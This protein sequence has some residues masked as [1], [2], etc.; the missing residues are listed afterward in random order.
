METKAIEFK[1]RLTYQ[2]ANS[3][4]VDAL[5]YLDKYTENDNKI[6]NELVQKEMKSFE[7][8]DYLK[9]LPLPKTNFESAP[10][11]KEFFD[12]YSKEN[13]VKAEAETENSIEELRKAKL[14]FCYNEMR[15]SNLKLLTKFG[16]EA[17]KRHIKDLDS[18]LKRIEKTVKN[19]E[20]T[21][22]AINQHRK[23][24][25]ENAETQIKS[26]QTEWSQLVKRNNEL[27]ILR[28]SMAGKVNKLKRP[29]I[30][31]E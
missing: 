30:D 7:P 4:L 24:D 10:Y 20:N 11:F 23:A 13:P 27:K 1:T 26:L 3:H 21:N 6:A 19:Y 15:N 9:E 31:K 22:T 29:K 25:Q 17:W 5:P 12:N 28:N 18:Y 2:I 16:A 14:Q 8:G